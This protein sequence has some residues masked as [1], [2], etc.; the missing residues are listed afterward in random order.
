MEPLQPFVIKVLASAF[1]ILFCVSNAELL[2]AAV[3]LDFPEHF[4]PFGSHLAVC[5]GL[6]GKYYRQ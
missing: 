4:F 5:A 1:A 2:S 3:E 6:S